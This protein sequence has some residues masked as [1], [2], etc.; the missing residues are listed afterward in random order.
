MPDRKQP[1]EIVDAVNID[2]RL[3]PADKFILDNGVE[4]YAVNA[5]AEDVLSL[6]WIFFAGNWQEEQNLVAATANF[7]LRNGTSEKSA[8][9][10]NDHFE[11]YGAYLNR[12]CYNE[13]ASI[14]LHCLTKH[15]RELL[16]VVKE[17]IT[18]SVMPQ[19]ELD[20]YKQ[21]MKQRLK[22]SLKKSDFVASRLIDVYLYG[23]QHPYGKYSRA[24]DF[25]VLNR[26]QLVDFYKTYY[27]HGK[28]IL[29]VAGKLPPD[30]EALLNQH[31]GDLPNTKNTERSLIIS[32]AEDKKYRIENDAK[33][34]QGSIRIA[35]PFPNRHHPDFLKVQMLNALFG[36]FFGSR[37]MSNIREDK[38]YTYGIHSYIQNHV[39]ETAWMISTEAGK[40]VCEATIAEV[41]KEMKDL[42]EELVDEEE[43]LLVR[44]YMMGGLLGDL[45]G[46]FQIIARWKNI[47]LNNLTEQYFYDSIHTIKTISAEELQDLAQKYLQPEDFYELVVV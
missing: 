41:Y 32:P 1:P 3:K 7:L 21:N 47:I 16:P 13:T 34:V 31:F 12:A 22:V 43:M 26:E 23:A 5:G 30:L 36:G 2:L 38:G 24:E 42:R 27:Q 35:R 20:I 39:H 25:D 37:L 40:D 14:T 45:D 28:L 29:F 8:Y 6:E 19:E 17:L 33:G 46:P 4:V 10:I 9:Q 15:V 44:N 18:D 11:Y